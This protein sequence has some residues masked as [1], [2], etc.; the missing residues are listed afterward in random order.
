MRTTAFLLLFSFLLLCLSSC[1]QDNSRPIIF[2]GKAGEAAVGE[3]IESVDGEVAEVAENSEDSEDAEEIVPVVEGTP[4]EEEIIPV[5]ESTPVAENTPVEEESTPVAENTPVEEESTPIDNPSSAFSFDEEAAT[6]LN[7]NGESGLNTDVGPCADLSFADITITAEIINNNIDIT[8]S[9]I[10]GADFTGTSVDEQYILEMALSY[11]NTT[12][13][14]DGYPIDEDV[15]IATKTD[16]CEK[17]L[18]KR[19]PRTGEFPQGIG[20]KVIRLKCL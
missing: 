11:D 4:V 7:E 19:N 6:C 13:L 10:S 18:K 8:G 14:G 20:E 9:D 15:L 12:L 16:L 5:I 1:G 2:E 17:W 3:S